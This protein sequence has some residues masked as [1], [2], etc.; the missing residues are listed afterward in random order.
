[1]LKNLSTFSSMMFC[2]F[3]KGDIDVS[4]TAEYAT[5]LL[6]TLKKALDPLGLKLGSCELPCASSEEQP[7]LIALE[8]SLQPLWFYFIII[9]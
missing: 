2:E 3:W 4:F 5:L 9:L 6:S 8:P 1:M 7:V